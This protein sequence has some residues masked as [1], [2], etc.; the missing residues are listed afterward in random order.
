MA[1]EGGCSCGAVRYSVAAER[2][3]GTRLCWCRGCQYRAAGNAT[4]NAIFESDAITS[5]GAI[6]WHESVADSGNEMK[7]GFCAK[8]GTQ[9]FSQSSGSSHLTVVRVG[10]LD[11]TSIGVPTSI[12]WTESAPAWAQLDPALP[13]H[14]KG[15]DSA[16]LNR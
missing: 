5:T 7:R 16:P 3:V 8:C 2:P 12:I 15:P 13:H 9:V 6:I 11:D 4:V 1:I 14:P 10:T